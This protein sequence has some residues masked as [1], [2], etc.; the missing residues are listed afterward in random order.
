[1]IRSIAPEYRPTRVQQSQLINTMNSAGWQVALDVMA[2][3]VDKYFIAWLNKD[4]ASDAEVLAAHKMNKAAA[5]LFTEFVERFN[6]E[7]GDFVSGQTEE[8]VAP[9]VTETLD[10]GDVSE[11]TPY[12]VDILEER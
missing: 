2:S 4:A 12:V 3:V 8:G 10:V 11:E 5:Q 6:F 1:M 9:D 7:R